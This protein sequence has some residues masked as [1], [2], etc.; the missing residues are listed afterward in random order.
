MSEYSNAPVVVKPDENYSPGEVVWARV[1]FANSARS[2]VR[3][4]VVLSR[5]EGGYT[6]CGCTSKSSW[7]GLKLHRRGAFKSGRL[8]HDSYAKP[9]NLHTIDEV[10]MFERVG[11]LK[12]RI[13]RQI[14]QAVMS[15]VL[16]L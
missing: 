9:G 12:R 10:V 2:K 3:P 6:V 1:P 7:G 4:V 5:G 15:V 16:G 14:V 11:V 13:F 8:L